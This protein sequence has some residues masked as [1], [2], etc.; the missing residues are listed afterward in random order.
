MILFAFFLLNYRIIRYEDLIHSI[1]KISKD[2]FAF[3]NLEF[4]PITQEFIDKATHPTHN[5]NSEEK[6]S[7]HIRDPNSGTNHLLH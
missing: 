3:M 5:M 6:H 1:K 4:Q 2:I 7:I